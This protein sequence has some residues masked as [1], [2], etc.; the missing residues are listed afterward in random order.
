MSVQAWHDSNPALLLHPPCTS[1]TVIISSSWLVI[2][3]YEHCISPWG[4]CFVGTTTSEH[5]WLSNTT[6][7]HL[8]WS[9]PYV[10]AGFRHVASPIRVL[11]PNSKC[12]PLTGLFKPTQLLNESP[13]LLWASEQFVHQLKIGFR[14]IVDLIS[15]QLYQCNIAHEKLVMLSPIPAGYCIVQGGQPLF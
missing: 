6:S 11:I 10:F 1:H 9:I 8:P 5:T 15:H 14:F 3:I 13:M 12:F 2:V 4:T 7:T